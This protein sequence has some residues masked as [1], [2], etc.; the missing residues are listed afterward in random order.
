MTYNKSSAANGLKVTA[1]VEVKEV[2]SIDALAPVNT[3]VGVRPTTGG[4]LPYSVEVA[5]TDGTKEAVQHCVG[6]YFGHA[7]GK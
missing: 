4:G 3:P 1:Q 2:A 7:G 6:P 5:F